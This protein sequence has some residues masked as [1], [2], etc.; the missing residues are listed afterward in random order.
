MHVLLFAV[1]A[2]IAVA[3]GIAVFVVDSMPRATFALALSFVAVG[4]ELI[5]LRA[6]YLGLITVLM[7]VMEM[8]IMAVFMVM[9]M[10]NHAG[11]MPMSMLHNRTGALAISLGIFV[12][13]GLGAVL[14]PWPARRGHAPADAARAL[15]ESIMG[16]KM[17]VMIGI[18]TVLFATMVSA[19]VLASARGRYDRD[20]Q[21]ATRAPHPQPQ[22]GH[23][24]H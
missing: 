17:L 14:V 5:T 21:P 22:P 13:L 2:L 8:A 24:D 3:A 15:G 16:P 9:F 23:G 18:S 11:L 10:M 12:A 4:A 20:P 19:L 7:M 6:G 1:L